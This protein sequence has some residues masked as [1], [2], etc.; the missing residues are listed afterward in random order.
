MWHILRKG[1][2]H[3][4]FCWKKLRKDDLEDIIVDGSMIL[5]WNWGT[6]TGLIWQWISAGGR[7][8]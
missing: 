1:E 3:T 4:G 8:F 7:L 6:W 2:V 5:K